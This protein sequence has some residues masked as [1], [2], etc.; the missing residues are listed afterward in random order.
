A[1]RDGVQVTYRTRGEVILSAGTI[2]SPK[3]L[4]L[5]GIGPATH[6]SSLGIP[7]LHDGP[8][9]GRCLRDHLGFSIP[10]RLTSVR[11]LNHRFRGVGLL[12]SLSQYYLGRT[13]PLA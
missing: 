7:V 11:G 8:D 9:V 1:K 6:L 4:Q 12:T 2:E 13:G 5:S 3:L 10:H